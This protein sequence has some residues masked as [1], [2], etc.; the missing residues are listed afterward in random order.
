MYSG[1]HG[2]NDLTDYLTRCLYP[3]QS[4]TVGLVYKTVI[5]VLQEL[6]AVL[7]MTMLPVSKS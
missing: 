6:A 3:T 2:K 7:C 1:E 5:E 4:R